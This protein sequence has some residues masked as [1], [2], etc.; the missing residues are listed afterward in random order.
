[1]AIGQWLERRD[2]ALA[3]NLGHGF[4]GHCLRHFEHAQTPG[5]DRRERVTPAPGHA[6]SVSRQFASRLRRLDR[7]DEP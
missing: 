6:D 5:S 2:R 3:L 1:M 4:G 7:K